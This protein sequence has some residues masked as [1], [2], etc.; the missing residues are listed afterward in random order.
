MV[1]LLLIL[2][3]WLVLSLNIPPLLALMMISRVMLTCSF[4]WKSPFPQSSCLWPMPPCEAMPT[5]SSRSTLRS[6]T[7]QHPRRSGTWSRRTWLSTS[8]GNISPVTGDAPYVTIIPSQML[9]RIDLLLLLR[10]REANLLFL[11]LNQ[12]AQVFPDERC[13]RD[14]V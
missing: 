5:S 4:I 12:K 14:T 6:S 13:L 7:S 2:S 8:T 1:S 9:T 10:D 11:I 3:T